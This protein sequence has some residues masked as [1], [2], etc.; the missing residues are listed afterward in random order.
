M[1]LRRYI[2][3]PT[4]SKGSKLLLILV[5]LYMCSILLFSYYES[6]NF[7][8]LTIFVFAFGGC[9][10]Y[11]IFKGKNFRIDTF[12][13]LFAAFIVF[14][15]ISLA[16]SININAS[17]STIITLIQLLI[18]SVILYSYI[19]TFE[20][21]E[22]FIYGFMISGM[23][24]AFVVVEYY[25]FGEY[26]RLMFLGER[27]G[28]MINNVNIVGMYLSITVIVAFYQAYFKGKKYCYVFMLFAVLVA[29]GTG[30]RKSVAMVALG[31]GLL[32][33]MKYRENISLT[34]FA[35]L[36]VA[37]IVFLIILNYISTMPIFQ[38]V[39][40]RISSMFGGES[41][42]V[43]GSASMRF[44]LIEA[45]WDSFKQRPY[46]GVGIDNARLVS[47][48]VLGVSLYMHNNFIELLV[49]VGIVGFLIYYAI[50]FY[51]IKNLYTLSVITGNTAT[52]LMFTI[53]VSLLVMDYGMVSYYNKITYIF[54]AMAAAT[55]TICKREIAN[56][57]YIINEQM[58]TEQLD[59]EKRNDSRV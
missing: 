27:L 13:M 1:Y 9:A 31:I 2:E 25:G 51:L 50:Y 52:T 54:F 44:S 35:K 55:I 12:I 43:D 23:I 15:F 24:C 56:Q 48:E 21:I 28:G 10:G 4:E 37:V 16:W 17:L 34:A 46:T 33:I 22:S 38:G 11:M 40:S 14:S 6:L 7:I 59:G 3:E 58:E 57:E 29:F 39:F 47:K 36:L 45:G 32:L 5:T 18:M 41:G 49:C 53:M 30:S 42:K 19:S 8:S 26:I 20:N